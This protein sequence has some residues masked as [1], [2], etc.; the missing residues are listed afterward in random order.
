MGI[1]SKVEQP[2][3]SGDVTLILSKTRL[4]VHDPSRYVVDVI[5]GKY[6][7]FKRFTNQPPKQ[8]FL[9]YIFKSNSQRAKSESMRTEVFGTERS[10]NRNN[11]PP[12]TPP[13]HPIK[14]CL[15]CRDRK[16]GGRIRAVKRAGPNKQ[17]KHCF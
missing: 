11:H 4:V 12:P 1:I 8:L 3:I 2:I 5:K 9:S 7:P 15:F 14:M 10:H 16:E 17:D 6:K 13:T